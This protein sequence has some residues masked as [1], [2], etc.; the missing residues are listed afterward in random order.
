LHFYKY[1]IILASP[2]TQLSSQIRNYAKRHIQKSFETFKL[3]QLNSIQCLLWYLSDELL[4]Y[5]YH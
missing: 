4:T 3:Y 2:V 1:C 5:R